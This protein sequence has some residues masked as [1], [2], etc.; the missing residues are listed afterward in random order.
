MTPISWWCTQRQRF[1]SCSPDVSAAAWLK[2]CPMC[3]LHSRTQT[4]GRRLTEYWYP[5]WNKYCHSLVMALKVLLGSGIHHK[6]LLPRTK[7][8]AQLKAKHVGECRALTGRPV[9]IC[10]A[11]TQSTSRSHLYFSVKF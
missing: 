6:T 3:L 4:E 5:Y 1:I 9:H 10:R 2:F 7:C 8:M 11:I